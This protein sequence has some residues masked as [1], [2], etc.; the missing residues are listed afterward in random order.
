VVNGQK[1]VITALKN[2]ANKNRKMQIFLSHR[3]ENG[4]VRKQ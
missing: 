1:A 4:K 3:N 2:S